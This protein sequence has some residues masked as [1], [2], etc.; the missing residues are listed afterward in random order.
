MATLLL[1]AVGSTRM[2]ASVAPANGKIKLEFS[3]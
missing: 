3:S 1:A 2:V